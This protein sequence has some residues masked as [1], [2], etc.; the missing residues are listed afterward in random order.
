MAVGGGLGHVAAEHEAVDEDGDEDE[1]PGT[2]SLGQAT[3]MTRDG[4]PGQRAVTPDLAT[5]KYIH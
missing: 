5:G 4:K 3:K 1:D 2:L